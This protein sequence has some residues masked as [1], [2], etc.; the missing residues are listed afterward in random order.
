M[1]R[2]GNLKQIWCNYEA[3]I[4]A[5]KEVKRNKSYNYS[6]LE[7]ENNLACNLDRLLRSLEE[8]TYKVRPTRDF[9][10]HDPKKRLIQA[11]HLEDRIVQHA[12]MNAIRDIL[13]RRLINQTYACIRGRGT[14][15][16]SNKLKQY[17]VLYKNK[18]YYLKVDVK[19]FFYSIDH[20]ILNRQLNRIIKCKDTLS[21]LKKFYDNSEG[22]GLP[23]GSVTSQILA[24]IALFPVDHF[25]KRKLKYKH[26]VRYMDDLIILSDN[27]ED[28]NHALIEIKMQLNRLKLEINNKT[29]IGKI[30]H[31]IDFVGYRTWYNRRLIR[32]RSLHKI[33]RIL[34]KHPDKNRIAS[35][36]SHSLRTNS[37]KRVIKLIL[38]RVPD[39]EDFIKQIIFKNRVEVYYE[40]F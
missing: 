4:T 14:H 11:P 37:L 22:K 38:D 1:K 20:E 6:L 21:L 35:Y 19:N 34:K 7:Y 2:H 24:N 16:A 25:I 12:L 39:S 30:A 17:L 33:K 29:H 23:L 40:I 9:Y 10:V 27:K 5:F 8:G 26:Y 31:G 32:K 28:L 13:V 18:G 3:L 36:L 15:A